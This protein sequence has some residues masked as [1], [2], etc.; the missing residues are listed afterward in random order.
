MTALTLAMLIIYSS[1]D[2]Q[3][4]SPVLPADV[5]DWLKDPDTIAKL[6]DGLMCQSPNSGSRTTWFRAERHLLPGER[7]KPAHRNLVIH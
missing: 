5:P 3:V 6:V 4:W 7:K 1:P 2:G